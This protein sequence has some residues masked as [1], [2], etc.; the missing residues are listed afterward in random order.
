MRKL[1]LL[2]AFPF[3]CGT[4]GAQNLSDLI[5]SEAL[6]VNTSSLIDD[7]G[8]HSP[9]LEIFNTSQGTVNFA[10]CF[11]TDD[12]TNLTKSQIPKGDLA[13]K[14]GPRQ[15]AVIYANG[16]ASKG[17]FYLNFE[18]RKGNTVYLVSNDGRTI[19]D[20]LA[21]PLVID[22][23]VSI[24]KFS[25]DNKGLIFNDI[26]P[27]APS[28]LSE[29]GR[30]SQKSNAQSI[31]ET[32]PHGWTLTVV[33]V[34]VV[35]FALFILFLLYNL[36]GNIFT[37]KFKEKSKTRS[38]SD[39]ETTAAAIALALARYESSDDTEAAIAL[40]LHLY[41]SDRVH[42]MEPGYITIRSNPDSAWRN[43]SLSFR[44]KT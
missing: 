26:Y 42:D 12:P 5:I 10:G 39:E 15:S 1:F 7:Y 36:S 25:H 31:Q 33:S 17:T 14:L 38:S 35:F 18:L 27:A 19:I 34:M 22:E 37:G 2:L 30:R 23:N 40:A 43:K 29:N 13:T 32:D 9:W 8:E 6:P 21:V 4:I 24:A 3:L 44:K 28:P 16:D 11:F 41:L 20:S